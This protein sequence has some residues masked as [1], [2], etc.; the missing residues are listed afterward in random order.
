LFILAFVSDRTWHILE[1]YRKDP[2]KLSTKV[3]SS[4]AFEAVISTESVSFNHLGPMF[5]GGK[6][7]SEFGGP[8]IAII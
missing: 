2:K 7:Y 5:I 4:P 6:Y 8:K 1:I 3:D